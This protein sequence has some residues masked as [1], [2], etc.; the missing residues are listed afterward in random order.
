MSKQR[1]LA[2]RDAH[3]PALCPFGMASQPLVFPLGPTHE[4]CVDASEEW[5]QPGLVEAPV[6]VDPSLHNF[7]EE[8]CKLVQRLVTTTIDPPTP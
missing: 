2:A 6:I 3:Q 5:I 1:R 7:V 8:V 4:V